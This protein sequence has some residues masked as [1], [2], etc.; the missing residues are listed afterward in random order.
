MIRYADD[1]VFCFQYKEAVGK[2]Y[3]KLLERLKEFTLE[4]AEKKTRALQLLWRHR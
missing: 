2:F 1:S 3:K 4:I